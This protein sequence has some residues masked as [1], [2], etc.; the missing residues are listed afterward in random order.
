MTQ[1]K[2]L[3]VLRQIVKLD[4]DYHAKFEHLA[5]ELNTGG[6]G[7]S[8]LRML[9]HV[10]RISINKC[11]DDVPSQVVDEIFAIDETNRS[12]NVDFPLAMSL[13]KSEQ[14]KDE[15][16]QAIISRPELQEKLSKFTFRNTEVHALE[17][18]ILVP[19][20]LQLRVIEWYHENLKHPRV[21]RTISSIAVVFGRNGM[22]IQVEDL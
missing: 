3:C 4:Q 12:T 14:D 15:R 8:R 20:S 9:D 17:G 22:H 7:F 18:K 2:N 13:I 16:I 5:G 10:P 6:D 1:H 11:Y 21:T 19:A